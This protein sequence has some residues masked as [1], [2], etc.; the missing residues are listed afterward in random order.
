MVR[1]EERDYK[2]GLKELKKMICLCI[3]PASS[4][5]VYPAVPYLAASLRKNNIE[6]SVQDINI[7]F[8]NLFSKTQ[9]LQIDY[10]KLSFI[11]HNKVVTY[12]KPNDI[13][14]NL[15][16]II[17]VYDKIL[18][19]IF[20]LLFFN[21]PGPLKTI[22]GNEYQKMLALKDSFMREISL[23][24][25]QLKKDRT[26]IAGF[27]IMSQTGLHWSIFLA[28]LIKESITDISIIF[29][30][31][32]MGYIGA[33]REQLLKKFPFIDYVV[34]GDGEEAILN[35]IEHLRGKSVDLCA[36]SGIT[37]LKNPC[38]A[39]TPYKCRGGLDEIPFPD[40][41]DLNLSLYPQFAYK[42]P[43]L[44]IVR[45]RGCP[46]KCVFCSERNLWTGYRERSPQ[47]V[48]EEIKYLKEKYEVGTFRF[49]DSLI[50]ANPSALEAMSGLLIEKKLNIKWMALARLRHGLNQKLLQKMR[51]SGCWSLWYGLESA[52][53]A[54]LSSM[55]K[56]IDL[57]EASQ[58]IKNTQQCG[59][60]AHLFLITDFPGETTEDIS[61][62][63]K[64]LEDHKNFITSVNITKFSLLL[65]SEI[66]KNPQD[67]G[68]DAVSAPHN[69]NINDYLLPKMFHKTNH[70]QILTQAW[71][72]IRKTRRPIIIKEETFLPITFV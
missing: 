9:D 27:S 41:S 58:I 39:I 35:I 59:I 7:N 65:F 1:G 43:Y 53:P 61:L 5:Q 48:V 25:S 36:P 4:M 3:P 26:K 60:Q 30:G 69:G 19:A 56:Q 54:L 46:Y 2:N 40:Y 31:S 22:S 66:Y 57:E 24:I 63:V 72:R 11:E 68:L 44:P 16:F 18:K 52:S 13:L 15:N 10:L 34:W 38:S 67:Y 29:G 55:K 47:N 21:D 23:W 32:L 20:E 6:V 14:E 70:E 33:Y 17:M 42:L 51:Q 50:D 8:F 71:D 37:S 45:S 62:T 49:N 28:K 64:F 12:T